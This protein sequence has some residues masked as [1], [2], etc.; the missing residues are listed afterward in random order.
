VPRPPLA[1]DGR[2]L[3]QHAEG[4]RVMTDPIPT[5]KMSG[6]PIRLVDSPRPAPSSAAASQQGVSGTVEVPGLAV[7]RAEAES[8]EDRLRDRVCLSGRLRPV[9][10]SEPR[11]LA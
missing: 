7:A 10:P 5:K 9:E 6:V 1:R 11:L 2:D 3:P 4:R 8:V